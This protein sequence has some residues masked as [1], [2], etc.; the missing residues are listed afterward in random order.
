[1]KFIFII[2]YKIKMQEFIKNNYTIMKK[3]YF[4]I[5]KFFLKDSQFV[6]YINLY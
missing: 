3:I 1:M 5:Y 2:L 4:Y 6:F